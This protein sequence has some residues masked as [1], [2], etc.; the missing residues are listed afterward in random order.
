ML[1]YFVNVL[2]SNAINIHHQK[3]IK[4]LQNKPTMESKP[5]E[6]L[7]MQSNELELINF[8]HIVI[9][10]YSNCFNVL[11]SKCSGIIWIWYVGCSLIG[12]GE[13]ALKSL[14]ILQ[15]PMVQKGCSD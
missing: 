7:T 10:K 3:R 5:I 1:L 2:M 6:T 4:D 8:I 15:T 12:L 14:S 11:M 13:L 9:I